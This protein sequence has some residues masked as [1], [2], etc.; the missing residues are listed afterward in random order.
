VA[1]TPLFTNLIG[2]R[3]A[4]QVYDEL[5][6]FPRMNLFRS[7]TDGG[8]NGTAHNDERGQHH[9]ELRTPTPIDELQEIALEAI[10]PLVEANAPGIR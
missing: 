9:P 6:K 2:P 4:D 1:I 5:I 7:E 8:D 3:T 10:A